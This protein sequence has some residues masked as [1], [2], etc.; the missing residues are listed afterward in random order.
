M[1]HKEQLCDLYSSP[2][3]VMTVKSIRL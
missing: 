3:I 2:R 1:L